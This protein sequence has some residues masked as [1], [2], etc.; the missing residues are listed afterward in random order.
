MFLAFL[1]HRNHELELQRTLVR[2]RDTEVSRY[3][4]ELEGMINEFKTLQVAAATASGDR[5]P[6]ARLAW[7]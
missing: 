3:Q 2:K 7:I 4:K 5:P 1:K 6:T